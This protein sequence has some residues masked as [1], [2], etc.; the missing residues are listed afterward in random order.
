MD[1]SLPHLNSHYRPD[2]RLDGGGGCQWV[3]PK[4]VP[5]RNPTRPYGLMGYIGG[6]IRAPRKIEF[7][8]VRPL[9]IAMLG[10]LAY[11]ARKLGK[12]KRRLE[13]HAW[14]SC[15][16]KRVP[17]AGQGPLA[18]RGTGVVQR[19]I[20]RM[21]VRGGDRAR[22]Q[23]ACAGRVYGGGVPATAPPP[24]LLKNESYTCP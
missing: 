10:T 3:P 19:N 17:R 20:E 15:T 24:T 22:T 8:R 14:G 2:F 13:T 1:A 6:L 7:S 11:N 23:G 12:P 4:G 21:P 5:Y 16:E 18:R 9:K